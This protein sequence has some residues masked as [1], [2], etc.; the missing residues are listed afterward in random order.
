MDHHADNFKNTTKCVQDRWIW[1]YAEQPPSQNGQQERQM[2]SCLINKSEEGKN[3][4]I[5]A[6]GMRQKYIYISSPNGNFYGNE[7]TYKI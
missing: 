6:S 2:P 5:G 7:E 1:I 3:I 4:A